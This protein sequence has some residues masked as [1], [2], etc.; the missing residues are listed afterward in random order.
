MF[1]LLTLLSSIQSGISRPWPRLTKRRD[2]RGSPF[3][4]ERTNFQ[5]IPQC[6]KTAIQNYRSSTLVVPLDNVEPILLLFCRS[7]V[8]GCNISIVLNKS[9]EL[10]KPF[11]R[12]ICTK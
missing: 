7:A 4:S 6:S 10:G 11:G 9:P 2:F 5:R 12:C 3:T 8:R 1:F